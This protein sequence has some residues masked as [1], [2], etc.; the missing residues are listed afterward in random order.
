MFKVLSLLI[1]GN[2]LQAVEDTKDMVSFLKKAVTDLNEQMAGSND[3][4]KN[5]T[6]QIDVL[7]DE[8]A[9][10]KAMKNKTCCPPPCC[11]PPC[12]PPPPK[13]LT[14]CGC[15]TPPCPLCPTQPALPAQPVGMVPQPP[16]NPAPMPCCNQCANGYSKKEEIGGNDESD[17]NL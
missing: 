7:R 15:V 3:F 13:P 11:P 4:V 9:K 2:T 6:A 1:S 5:L 16:A 14:G 17:E 12:P 8:V 10:L